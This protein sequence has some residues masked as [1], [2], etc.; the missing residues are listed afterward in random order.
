MN[1]HLMVPLT[2][3]AQISKLTMSKH[4]IVLIGSFL[5]A[6]YVLLAFAMPIASAPIVWLIG[7]KLD[8]ESR[9]LAGPN[10]TNCGRVSVNSDGH[11]A[12]DCVLASFHDKRPFRVRYQT[13]SI[14]E[15]SAIGIVGARDGQLYHLG[16]LGGS[17]DGGVSFSGQHVSIWPCPDPITFHP[18]TDWGKERGIISCRQNLVPSPK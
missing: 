4:R 2:L 6:L 11:K 8:W 9:R 1:L 14:D 15:A 12:S 17:P 10:A 3:N 5:L 18:E 7:D 16:F 13:M